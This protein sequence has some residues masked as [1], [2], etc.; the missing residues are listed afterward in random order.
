LR[1]L[2]RE[3]ELFTFLVADVE[4]I[5]KSFASL[6]FSTSGDATPLILRL[7]LALVFFP[8]GAQKVL[9]WFG[10]G[11]FEGTM[12]N[13]TGVLHIPYAIA[14][15]PILTDFLAPFALM[16]GFLTRL[17]A[18]ALAVNMAVA[19]LMVH[20]PNGFFMNWDGTQKG[21]GF[22][23]HILAIGLGLAL[24]V[25]GAGRWSVDALLATS[26]QKPNLVLSELA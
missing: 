16:A 20:L 21:E 7:T 9:G 15:L 26:S 23:Y 8:H 14:L 12:E 10:G 25:Q 11:G 22:E 4:V 5:M 6:L 3:I 19:V 13:L 24:I 18:F 2:C 17:A 1:R